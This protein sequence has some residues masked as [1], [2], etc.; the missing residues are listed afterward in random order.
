L[1]RLRVSANTKVGEHNDNIGSS[2]A[3][4]RIREA[5]DVEAYKRMK[6]WLLFFNRQR[7]SHGAH[8]RE[9]ATTI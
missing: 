6:E 4:H 3:M 7:G 5:T 8:E 9:F 2:N 1:S